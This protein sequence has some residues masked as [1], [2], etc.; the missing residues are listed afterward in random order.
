MLAYDYPILG[1]FWTMLGIY[2]LIA[3]LWILFSVIADV[4]R[5]QDI[6]GFAKAIWL[7]G[8]LFVPFI[9]VVVYL[10]VHGGRMASRK[11]ASPSAQDDAFGGYYAPDA[12]RMPRA[13][14][15]LTQLSSLHDS[16]AIT[17]AEFESGKA[18]ILA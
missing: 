15:Q 14:D 10:A 6:G 5:N 11:V 2:I 8:I 1:L 17:D 7:L 18:K 4:F 9:G 12:T 13:G 16:G 3:W